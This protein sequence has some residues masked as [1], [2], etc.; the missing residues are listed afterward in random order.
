MRNILLFVTFLYCNFLI[1][2]DAIIVPPENVTKSFE[3]QYPKKTVVWS[4]EYGKDE[5]VYFEGEFTDDKKSKAIV[6]YDSNGVFK[7][8]KTQITIVKL[9]LKSQNYLKKNYPDKGKV[10]SVGKI[11]YMIDDKNNE[12]YVAVAK[13]DKKLY[14]II[15][16]KNG[17]YVKRIEIHFL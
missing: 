12:T 14:N 7:T 9:P 6:L 13:K 5:D 2:Q 1:A 8:L 17:E 10:K 4:I 3:S 15:F 16:D 11:F